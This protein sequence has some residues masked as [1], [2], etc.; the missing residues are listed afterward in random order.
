MRAKEWRIKKKT[1]SLI[2]TS[3]E[4]VNFFPSFF[5]YP[6]GTCCGTKDTLYSAYMYDNVAAVYRSSKIILQGEKK[7]PAFCVYLRMYTCVCICIRSD[8]TL[9]PGTVNVNCEQFFFSFFFYFK[10][11]D[12]LFVLSGYVIR[13]R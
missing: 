3:E 1:H 2:N 8:I 4:A 13:C 6:C 5:E 12:A 11:R 7:I 10:I 9:S